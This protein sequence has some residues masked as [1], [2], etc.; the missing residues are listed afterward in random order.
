MK[1]VSIND[2]IAYSP[3]MNY[4]FDPLV[5]LLQVVCR[6]LSIDIDCA[7][8]ISFWQSLKALELNYIS[9]SRIVASSILSTNG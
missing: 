2:D 6:Q 7:N 1:V 5:Q 4:N 3:I 8:V 9:I